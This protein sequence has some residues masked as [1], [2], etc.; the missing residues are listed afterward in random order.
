YYALSYVWGDAVDTE[1]IRVNGHEFHATKNLVLNYVSRAMWVDATC[2][3]QADVSERSAQVKIM[4]QIYKNVAE[5]LC[6][7]GDEDDSSAVAMRLITALSQDLYES[8][9]MTAGTERLGFTPLK[10]PI[11]SLSLFSQRPYWTRIWTL[12]EMVL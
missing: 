7:L 8:P 1:I 12:Q 5:V 9:E 4:D 3:N 11:L 6:W 2:I 10:D